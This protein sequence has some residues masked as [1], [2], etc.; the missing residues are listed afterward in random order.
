MKRLYVCLLTLSIMLTGTAPAA[1]LETDIDPP[2]PTPGRPVPPPVTPPRPRPDSH[3]PGLARRVSIGAPR[4]W[5]HLTF[6]PLDL[7][8]RHSQ[9]RI[10]TLDEASRRGD[11]SI[12]EV[13]SGEVA[14]LS[15]RNRASLPVFLMAGELIL[16]GKQNRMVRDDVLLPPRSNWVTI[17]VYCGEQHRWQGSGAFKSGQTLSSPALRRMATGGATQDRIWSSIEGQLKAAEVET[18]TA[19]YQRLFESPELRRRL[20]RCVETLAPL[21]GPRTVGCIVV[22]GQR[23]IG[24]DLF[25]D[26]GLFEDL[27]PKLCRSYAADA[28]PPRPEH[29]PNRRHWIPPHPD[30][31]QLQRFLNDLTRTGFTRRTTPGDGTLW[32]LHGA[33]EGSSLEHFNGVIHAGFFPTQ[34]HIQPLPRGE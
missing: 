10:L 32:R 12:N 21:P 18:P 2:P 9:M 34:V 25:G 11:L 30:P 23:I 19:S 5:G 15:I 16:G 4:Q 14:R 33:V 17:S 8:T 24:G 20:D 26:P 31:A 3:L 28:M 13:G 27:W 1:Y 6:Y 7:P 29:R 22:S